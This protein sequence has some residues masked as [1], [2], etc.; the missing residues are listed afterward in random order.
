M[1][2]NRGNDMTLSRWC[3][4][5]KPCHLEGHNPSRARHMSLVHP[6]RV[7][8]FEAAFESTIGIIKFRENFLIHRHSGLNGLQLG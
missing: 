6:V 2:S 7:A 5:R 8:L 1:D 4:L 3:G